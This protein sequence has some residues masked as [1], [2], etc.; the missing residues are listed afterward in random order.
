M[1]EPAEY[2]VVVG[3]D[4][5]TATHEVCVL[6]AART[7]LATRR[8]PHSAAGLDELVALLALYG[9][10]ATVAIGIEMP[11]GALIEGLLAH[12]YP[13]YAIN[14]KQ[15][16]RFRD[17]HSLAGAKDDR[18]DA[19]VIADALRTDR[20]CFRRVQP[21]EATILQIREYSRMD[22][23]LRD[24]HA[25]LTNR[26][27][28]Q[29]YRYFPQLLALCP[30]ADEPWVWAL[31][32]IA[33]TPEAARRLRRPQLAARLKAHRI[34]RLTAD[35]V[36]AALAAPAISVSAGTIAAASAHVALLLPRLALVQAQQHTCAAALATLLETLSTA[37]RDHDPTA[38]TPSDVQIIRSLPG[39]GLKT[40]AALLAEAADAIATRDLAALRAHAGIAPVTRRSGTRTLV[41]MRHAC[42][43]R[44]R[45]ALYH[46]SRVSAQCDADAKQMYAA[47]RARGHSHGRACRSVADRMLRILMAML[48][49]GTTY[50]SSLTAA[51]TQ[52]T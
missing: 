42:S 41:V 36:H 3:I 31:L 15:S 11:R 5:A 26:L 46:A 38:S 23:E 6:N 45:N 22:D 14:P 43:G 37:H 2:P 50:T 32:G 21:D 52:P 7:V 8:I 18:L 25:R 9:P 27:R 30:A 40:A 24:E 33:A 29:L 13:V 1:T 10:A 4:W 28:A 16:D 35:D 51:V 12:G 19:F 47:L 34:R 20:P 48:R 44:L 17:R 39:V 49:D